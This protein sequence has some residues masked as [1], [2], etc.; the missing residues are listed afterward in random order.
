VFAGVH[1]L[2]D[3]VWYT[4]IAFAIFK[5]RRFWTKRIHEGICCSASSSSWDSTYFWSAR[6]R[7]SAFY[8]MDEVVMVKNEFRWCNR[9]LHQGRHYKVA[10]DA[11]ERG[12]QLANG[13]R[14]CRQRYSPMADR[15]Y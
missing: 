8:R 3:F 11:S 15:K 7:Q 4:I 14:R 9:S 6:G 1:W 12:K 2:C 10:A 5:S 13:R